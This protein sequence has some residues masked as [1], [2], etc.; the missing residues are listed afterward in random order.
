MRTATFN[1]FAPAAAAQRR[2]PLQRE[3]ACIATGEICPR[4]EGK[5][6]PMQRKPREARATAYIPPAVERVLASTGGAIDPVTRNFMES[7]FGHDFSGVRVHT[8]ELAAESAKAINAHAYTSGSSIVFGASRYAPDTTEGR[9]LLAHELTHVVQQRGG[10]SS[11]Q[12]FGRG[13]SIDGHRGAEAQADAVADAVLRGGAL[14]AIGRF[15]LALA[16]EADRDREWQ[17][18][19]VKRL[20]GCASTRDGGLPDPA[21]LSRYNAEC[22]RTTGFEEDVTPTDVECKTPQREAA[23]AEL[24]FELQDAP[25]SSDPKKRAARWLMAHRAEIES[26]EL[27]FRVDR[28]AIAGAIAW[29]AIENVRAAWT[30]SSVGPGKVHIHTHRIA[31]ENTVAKQVED[32][33]YLPPKSFDDRKKLLATAEGSITY[34]GAIM[35]AG[36]DIA[37]AKGLDIADDP[38]VLTWFYNS[39]DLP[40]WEEHLNKRAAGTAFKT[41]D[42]PMSKWVQDNMAAL[43]AAVGTPHLSE[44]A[45]KKGPVQKQSADPDAQASKD[46]LEAEADAA[47]QEVTREP[48]LPA[49]AQATPEAVPSADTAPSAGQPGAATPSVTSTLAKCPPAPILVANTPSCIMPPSNSVGALAKSEVA[50]RIPTVAPG[51]FGGEAIIADFASKLARCRAERKVA[52]EIDDRFQSAKKSAGQRADAQATQDKQAAVAAAKAGAQAQAQGDKRKEAA[53]TRTAVAEASKRADAQAKL[54]K[55]AATSA[56]VRED[57]APVTQE[58]QADYLKVLVADYRLTMETVLRESG[59]KWAAGA[60]GKL[61]DA[62]KKRG[63]ELKAKPKVKK[64][65]TAPPP[66][67]E[68]DIEAELESFMQDQRCQADARVADAFAKGKTGWMVGRRE[69][70]DFDTATQPAREM[71]PGFAAPRDTPE[72]DLVQIPSELTDSSKMPGVAPE[73]VG[74]LRELQSKAIGFKV[75][76]YAG[77]GSWKFTARDAV[78]KGSHSMGF[79]VDITLDQVKKDSRGFWD[80]QTAIDF[81]LDLDRAAA[82]AGAEWRVLYNDFSVAEE[83]NRAIGVKRV[84]FTGNIDR[85]G[86]LNWHGP[87]PHKLHFHLDISPTVSLPIAKP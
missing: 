77:H 24:S 58:L 3:C 70:V 71:T 12:A 47:A 31:G 26:A 56:V 53:A 38:L 54:N 79:S 73:V 65:E 14:P 40:G 69:Q 82:K 20:G 46:P 49:T 76:N 6:R 9:R 83:V 43:E 39:K 50:P 62:R 84:T 41:V 11:V 78:G 2:V 87:A 32:R 15:D 37:K 30:P 5:Q 59:G 16:R 17:A 33:H 60:L 28:R 42:N 44:P 25:I 7:R 52:A 8:D 61:N 27:R 19:C 13:A 4:C 29:E 81:L 72:A 75:S 74:F 48:T 67:S 45:T 35:R 63:T 86:N 66:K 18:A 1:A 21:I 85:G 64:G 10:H 34:I 55:V 57:V 36:A 23:N 22:R 51:D 80:P 68:A